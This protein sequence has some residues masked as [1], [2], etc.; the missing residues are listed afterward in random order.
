M[1]KVVL[2][3]FLILIFF[4]C[5]KATKD[6]A[7]D[8]IKIPE[9]QQQGI[10]FAYME[11]L[12]KKSNKLNVEVFFAISVLHKKYISD[13]IEETKSMPEDKQKDFFEQKKKEFF[14]T[15]RFSEDEYNN[16][17][18]KHPDEINDYISKNQLIREYLTTLN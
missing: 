6:R 13:F 16:F 3:I 12:V 17:M 11:N 14:K 5:K 7:E 9:S 10:D 18:K 1:K 2:S 4:T 8:I 15:I